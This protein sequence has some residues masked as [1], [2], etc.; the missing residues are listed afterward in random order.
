VEACGG[1]LV[2]EPAQGGTRVRATLPLA[3]VR[4]PDTAGLARAAG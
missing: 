2:I 4:A 1:T 3:G